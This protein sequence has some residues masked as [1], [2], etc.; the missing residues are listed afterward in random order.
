[1]GRGSGAE[2]R[3]IGTTNQKRVEWARAAL[4]AYAP[5]VYGKPLDALHPEDLATCLTD[6]AADLI[7]FSRHEGV[8]FERGLASAGSHAAAEK[9][10][11]WDEPTD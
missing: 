4:A 3:A 11:A 6:L 2:G 9:R 7:H 8:D 1:M 5:L 10:F